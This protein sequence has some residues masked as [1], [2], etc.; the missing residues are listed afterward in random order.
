MCLMLS[1]DCTSSRLSY[2]YMSITLVFLQ[3]C[4]FSSHDV[5]HVRLHVSPIWHCFSR[6]REHIHAF[7][8]HSY[9]LSKICNTLQKLT[10]LISDCIFVIHIN[11]RSIYIY[12]YVRTTTNHSHLFTL[13]YQ[14]FIDLY[15]VADLETMRT[16]TCEC[17]LLLIWHC[18][19]CQIEGIHAHTSHIYNFPKSA[20]P[21]LGW[22]DWMRSYLLSKLTHNQ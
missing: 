7:T 20:K 22:K 5:R 10:L 4:R 13:K 12:I 6:Q 8:S 15:D 18:L 1:T 21:C 14:W 9:Q 17:M 16:I 19:P 3:P 2:N 11:T